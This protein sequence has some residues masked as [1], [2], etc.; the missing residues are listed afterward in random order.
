MAIRA[1]T[2]SWRSFEALAM[3]AGLVLGVLAQVAQFTG[4]LNFLRQIELQLALEHRDFITESLEN[5]VFHR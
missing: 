4:A 2:I 1:L 5:P 3:L